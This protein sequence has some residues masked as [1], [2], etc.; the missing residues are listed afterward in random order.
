M[1]TPDEC[2]TLDLIRK[3]LLED[4]TSAESFLDNL[5][6]QFP[7]VF[8]DTPVRRSGEIGS[9]SSGSE[10]CSDPKQS[11]DLPISGS[12]DFQPDFFEVEMKPQISMNCSTS[13]NY[14]DPGPDDTPPA[15]PPPMEKP[16][17]SDLECK[18]AFGS[19]PVARLGR[20]Y[21][22]VRR[23]P[24]G[25]YAAEIRDPIRK[26]SRVWLGTYDTAVDAAKAYDCAAFKMRGSKAILNFPMDAGKYG[27][28]A[29]A[30]RRRRREK[31]TED[32]ADPSP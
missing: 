26:G 21:R 1:A 4:F 14:D 27:P 25:K 12:L 3:H 11:Q 15:L 23:R 10:S 32:C 6:L 13:D 22:G 16:V 31:M 9:P 24:W 7:D 5:N 18:M 19:E 29:S 17:K 20:R 8:A 2:L 28:P 30:G